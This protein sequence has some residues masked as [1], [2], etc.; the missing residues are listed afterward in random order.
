VERNHRMELQYD[1]TGLLGWAKQPGCQTV[2]G[3]LEDALRTVLG[4]APRLRVAGRT[5]AGVHARRQVVSLLLPDR[6]ELHKLRRSL[7]AL[8]P[9]AIA[10]LEVR[11]AP[12]K[13]DARQD[14]SSR[15]YRYF[16]S[17][18]AVVSPFWASY[19]WHVVT[20]DLDTDALRTAAG[21]VAGR[22]DFTAFTPTETGH[23]FFDRTVLKCRWLGVGETSPLRPAGAAA[24]VAP[25]LGG[26][27]AQ[28]AG[29]Q[30][31]RRAGRSPGRGGIL[32]L[33]V[34]ADAFLRHMVRT[35]VGT[36]V[37]VGRGERS[38]EDFGRLLDGAPRAAAGLTAPAHGL[39]LWDI[40]YRRGAGG[41]RGTGMDAAT[42]GKIPGE[43]VG[44]MNGGQLFDETT[45]SEA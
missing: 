25:R 2:E 3:Y 5:D 4:E 28:S 24:R 38:L 22:H 20:G 30:R 21:L 33:E 12:A 44:G 6:Q 10:I 32:C 1:G 19:C 11:P 26:G 8:T 41:G 42:Y 15:T 29:G 9:P 36:I 37:E 35:L 31:R 45:D 40:R 34:E 13:F 16:V 7:N 14:A 39:F 43:A 23:A 17:A 18:E 27:V